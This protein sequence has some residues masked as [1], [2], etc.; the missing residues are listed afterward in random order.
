MADKLHKTTEGETWDLVSKRYYKS[1][2]LMYKLLEANG[3]FKDF[4]VFPAGVVLKIPE[5]E[6]KTI[7]ELPPWRK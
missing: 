7:E 4:V 1:E 3:E 5:F 6:I 2:K